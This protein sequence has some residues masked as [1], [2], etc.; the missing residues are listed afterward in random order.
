MADL[1]QRYQDRASKE[2]ALG[3]DA[4]SL[5]RL[6]ANLP[7][8]PTDVGQVQVTQRFGSSPAQVLAQR[9][10]AV[11]QEQGEQQHQTCQRRIDEDHLS[12]AAQHGKRPF[13]AGWR[14]R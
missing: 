7:T 11:G 8:L 9:G 14:R 5:E 12:Q 1:D 2:K 10:A 6:L 3:Q 13:Q 4:R